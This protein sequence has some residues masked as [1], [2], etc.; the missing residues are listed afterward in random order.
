MSQSDRMYVLSGRVAESA[1]TFRQ[2]VD[3]GKWSDAATAQAQL[4]KSLD[5]SEALLMDLDFTGH[6]RELFGAAAPI[7]TGDKGTVSTRPP[8]RKK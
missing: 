5:E 1:N 3:N 2:A 7:E 6:A 4:R 8:A